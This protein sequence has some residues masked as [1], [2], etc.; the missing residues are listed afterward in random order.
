MSVADE[1]FLLDPKIEN[2]FRFALAPFSAE[3]VGV[4]GRVGGLFAASSLMSS[5]RD[6][7]VVPKSSFIFELKA[8]HP[9]FN[10]FQETLQVRL[11][12][13]PKGVGNEIF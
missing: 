10:K 1:V 5:Q 11:L 3:V 12:P 7:P 9:I 6:S 2:N 13:K 4:T 8:L